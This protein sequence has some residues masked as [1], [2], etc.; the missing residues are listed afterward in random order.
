[1][2]VAELLRRMSAREFAEWAVYE[3][4]Y[5]PIGPG[6]DDALAALIAF[7]V[8]NV[9]RDSSKGPDLKPADFLPAWEPPTEEAGVG[10]RD[11][12]PPDP[13]DRF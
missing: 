1:M 2:T 9:M 11:Q 7:H 6:R 5:G 3:G 8:V 10:E 13:P 4:L 12:E